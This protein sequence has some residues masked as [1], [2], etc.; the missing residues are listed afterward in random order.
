MRDLWYALYVRARFEKYVQD[1]LE[2]R[3]YEAFLPEYVSKPRGAARLRSISLP[4]FPNYLFCRFNI[5]PQ[6]PVLMTPGVVLIAGTGSLPVPVNEKEILA[7]RNIIQSGL[8]ARPW[9]YMNA[10][11]MVWIETGPLEGTS[12]I[13]VKDGTTDRLIVSVSLLKRSVAVETDRDHV[14]PVRD[15][16]AS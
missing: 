5:R 16:D 10:G 11:R 2:K 9:R 1:E 13:L 4:L 6:H 7:V 3:G 15:G 14:R 8:A 12:G